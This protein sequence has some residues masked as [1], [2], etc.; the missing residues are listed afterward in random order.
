MKLAGFKNMSAYIRKMCIDGYT[1]NLQIA[2][3]KDISSS[4]AKTGSNINQIARRLNSGG[5]VYSGEFAEAKNAFDEIQ[6]QFG[7]ILKHLSRIK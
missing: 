2:E 3:L 1:V 5:E 7:E 6:S 4:L